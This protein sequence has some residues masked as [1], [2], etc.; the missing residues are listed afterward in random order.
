MGDGE[1]IDGPYS[2][3]HRFTQYRDMNASGM[4]TEK[5]IRTAPH[6]APRRTFRLKADAWEEYFRDPP[7][8]T[9]PGT[10]DDASEREPEGSDSSEHTDP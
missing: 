6:P 3:F 4:P 2:T 9:A 8:T 10:D 1:R 7:G 5:H